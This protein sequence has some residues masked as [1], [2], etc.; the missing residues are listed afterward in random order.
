MKFWIQVTFNTFFPQ[1]CFFLLFSIFRFYFYSSNLFRFTLCLHSSIY[2]LVLVQ[3]TMKVMD[4]SEIRH[5]KSIQSSL[6][7]WLVAGGRNDRGNILYQ[8]MQT[9]TNTNTI[10][11]RY[12]YYK[13]MLH[14]A[15]V[16]VCACHH[17]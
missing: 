6:L 10:H 2:P 17:R 11:R 13:D 4:W 14:A 12:T 16:C 1:M 5:I 8:H 15:R 7:E 3:R 9:N